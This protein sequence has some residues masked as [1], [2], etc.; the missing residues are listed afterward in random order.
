MGRCGDAGTGLRGALGTA[1]PVPHLV[2]SA[3]S[4]WDAPGGS[5]APSRLGLTPNSSF[6]SNNGDP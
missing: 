4:Q 3:E 6:S 5:P 2:G 1:D